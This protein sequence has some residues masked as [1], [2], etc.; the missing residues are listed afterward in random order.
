MVWS[1]AGGAL[2]PIGSAIVFRLLSTRKSAV[3]DGFWLP[4]SHSRL[5]RLT[6]QTLNISIECDILMWKFSHH[7]LF[8]VHSL[9]LVLINSDVGFPDKFIWKDKLHLK[10]KFFFC[11]VISLKVSFLRT[12][13]NL[14]NS[15]W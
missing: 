11:S 5:G 8:S 12:K 3:C 1:A 9:Y 2:P 14:Y 7:A 15:N 4:R 10:N 13:D 6:K